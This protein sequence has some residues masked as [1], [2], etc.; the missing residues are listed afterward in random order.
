M[1]EH[2]AEPLR[3]KYYNPEQGL[4]DL[5][6]KRLQFERMA[7]EKTRAGE[8][9]SVDEVKERRRLA[10]E[11]VRVLD[12]IFQSMANLL[13]FFEWVAG[14]KEL[15]ELFDD[16]IID[17]LGL[18]LERQESGQFDYG[19]TITLKNLG[20]ETDKALEDEKGKDQTNLRDGK[21]LAPEEPEKKNGSVENEKP[22]QIFFKPDTFQRLIRAMLATRNSNEQGFR[23][24]LLYIM[25]QVILEK[26]ER[27]DIPDDDNSVTAIMLDDLRRAIAWTKLYASE[28]VMEDTSYRRAIG[29]FPN[30]NY[31]F[32]SYVEEFDHYGKIL[33]LEDISSPVSCKSDESEVENTDK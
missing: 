24:S 1:P 5:L 31:P 17:L 4:T 15:Q 3:L 30:P 28:A 23:L 9:L 27:R 16:D 22:Y 21:G 25:Q 8:T 29:H 32:R 26:V 2:E 11:K 14:H 7:L 20:K 12:I 10:T 6:W 18:K 33:P 19:K 13:F